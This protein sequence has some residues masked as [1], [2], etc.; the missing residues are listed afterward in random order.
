[1]CVESK[2]SKILEVQV[3]NL[4]S[5]GII[6]KPEPERNVPSQNQYYIAK[7]TAKNIRIRNVDNFGKIC[8]TLI[9]MKT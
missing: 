5:K 7:P 6:F 2:S 8:E 9:F 4:L 3:Y 1:M